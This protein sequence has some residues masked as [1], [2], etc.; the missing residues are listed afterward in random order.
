MG[1]I[2]QRLRLNTPGRCQAS[3]RSVS[4]FED[5]ACH[6]GP[7]KHRPVNQRMHIDPDC[8]M[9]VSRYS[10]PDPEQVSDYGN[11]HGC[12]SHYNT[13]RNDCSF[14]R[15]L[16]WGSGPRRTPQGPIAPRSERYNRYQQVHG[17]DG[18]FSVGNQHDPYKNHGERNHAQDH[19]KNSN[20][21]AFDVPTAYHVL[22]P[23][24]LQSF[25]LSFSSATPV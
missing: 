2:Y 9:N 4:I 24:Q 3:P 23:T 15:R 6:K 25:D 20:E 11:D 8:A 17:S 13:L 22:R 7:Q 14:G 12:D 1:R 16:R 21:D 18:N 10:Q 5:E 19:R